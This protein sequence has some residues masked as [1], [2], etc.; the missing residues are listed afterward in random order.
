MP[1]PCRS[2]LRGALS[3]QHAAA[4]PTLPYEYRRR[5]FGAAL[6]RSSTTLLAA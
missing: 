4:E 1:S 3:G 5:A 6:G 2:F